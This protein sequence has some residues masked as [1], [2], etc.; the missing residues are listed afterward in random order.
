MTFISQQRHVRYLPQ[1][2]DLS[3]CH[4][5]KPTSTELSSCPGCSWYAHRY[6]IPNSMC[7]LSLLRTLPDRNVHKQENY[8]RRVT[9]PHN[10]SAVRYN[11]SM[12]ADR[13]CK[14]NTCNEGA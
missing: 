4:C 13:I 2:S 7:M 3:S 12:D 10:A 9:D 11:Y 14:G 5:P 8:P 6:R 1:S